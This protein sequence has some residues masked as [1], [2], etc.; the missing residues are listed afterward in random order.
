MSGKIKWRYNVFRKDNVLLIIQHNVL[1]LKLSCS[2]WIPLCFVH[3]IIQL[4]IIFIELSSSVYC[5]QN[6]PSLYNILSIIR[7]RIKSLKNPVLQ[8][9]F[10]FIQQ[11][12]ISLK[13]PGAEWC[14]QNY[15]ALG[16]VIEII[17]HCSM[18]LHL[19][20][21]SK[22]P[23]NCDIISTKQLKLCPRNYPALKYTFGLFVEMYVFEL[24]DIFLYLP[25]YIAH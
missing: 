20:E 3:G 17:R 18:S 16:Y 10:A 19:S 14:P 25:N 7:Q 5:P 13:S 8:N 4:W 22:C 2:V 9:D 23:L 1:S 6:Y 24:S 12:L 11:G 21:T 15:I